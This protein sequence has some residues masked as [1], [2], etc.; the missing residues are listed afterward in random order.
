MLKVVKGEKVFKGWDCGSLEKGW[1][2][3]DKTGREDVTEGD[4][5]CVVV[6]NPN[7]RVGRV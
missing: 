4:G 2:L 7:L 6:L 1:N 3:S 5:R